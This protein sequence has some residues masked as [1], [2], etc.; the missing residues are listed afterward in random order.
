VQRR[1]VAFER[2]DLGDWVA[3]LDCHH[4]QHVRDR[5]PL[6]PA[7][8]VLDDATREERVGSALD[9][10]LCD[11]TEVPA[12]LVVVRTTPL[13]D[14]HSMP[15]ALRRSHRV[16]SGVWGR[17]LVEQGRLRFVARTTPVVDVVVDHGHAQGIPPDVEHFIEPQGSARFSVEFLAPQT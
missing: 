16:A 13:W 3:L 1:I 14:E 17:L 5:P 12:D 10:P 15:Q 2:D 6:W 9:C 7:A 11:R 4:R 8:W